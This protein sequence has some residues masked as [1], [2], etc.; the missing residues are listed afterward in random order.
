MP[1]YALASPL[2]GR[3][4][5]GGAKISEGS[6]GRLVDLPVI[7]AVTIAMAPTSGPV[8]A[9]PARTAPGRGAG[10]YAGRTTTFVLTGV[11]L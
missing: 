6:K 9:L 10:A 8:V 11:R 7:A 3:S 4:D 1:I 5:S 2:S